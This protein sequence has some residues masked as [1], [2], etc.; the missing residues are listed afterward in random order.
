[1]NIGLIACTASPACASSCA[2]AYVA[3]SSRTPDAER[4][5][6][7]RPRGGAGPRNAALRAGRAV[8]SAPADQAGQTPRYRGSAGYRRWTPEPA[9]RDTPVREGPRTTGTETTGPDAPDASGHVVAGPTPRRDHPLDTAPSPDSRRRGRQFLPFR[10]PQA[11]HFRQSLISTG[12]RARWSEPRSRVELQTTK[13]TAHAPSNASSASELPHPRVQPVDVRDRCTRR[14]PG[15]ET[16]PVRAR[17]ATA[18][19]RSPDGPSR[20]RPSV[21]PCHRGPK[22]RRPIGS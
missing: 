22:K 16:L 9:A 19:P 3:S 7:L 8:C 13:W 18:G 2:R 1:M 11:Q 21:P 5:V 6:A 14:E 15:G 20:A 10:H 17:P 4:R 12:L